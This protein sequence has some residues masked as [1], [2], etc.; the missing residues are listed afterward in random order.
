MDFV[1]R[2]VTFVG[3]D[4]LNENVASRI[5]VL[6][7]RARRDFSVVQPAAGTKCTGAPF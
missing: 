4:K 2:F 7:F 6:I 1:E 5:I 3:S